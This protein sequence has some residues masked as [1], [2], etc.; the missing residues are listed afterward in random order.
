[1]G[2]AAGSRTPLAIVAGALGSGKTTLLR[3]ILE[4]ADRRYAVLMNEFGEIAIDSK[5]IAGK[6]VEIVELAGGCVCCSMT[7]ELEAAVVELIDRAAPDC[8]VLEATGVAEADALVYEVEERIPRVRLD[9]VV[10]VVDADASVR[11]PSVGYASRSQLGS[12]D[13]VL[14]NKVD[15]VD[16]PHAR[17]VAAQVGEFNPTAPIVE[18]VRCDV[19]PA[20]LFGPR[21]AGR[22]VPAPPPRAG[23]FESFTWETGGTLDASRF[24]EAVAC[25]P[26]SVFRAKGF[27]RFR[28]GTRLFNYVA[29][30]ADLEEFP[31][32]RT[33]LVF[34]GPGVERDREAIEGL[35]RDCED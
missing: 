6:A 17:L 23:S 35:L 9:T 26:P 10:C 11:F 8:I 24:R 31:A 2:T 16:G 12:A 29:G 32:E 18:T 19:D 21:T 1:M 33:E 7:G 34:I 28:E 30:R 13:I 15:L 14:L 25:L 22:E 3:R 20:L 27:I 4:R 5:V